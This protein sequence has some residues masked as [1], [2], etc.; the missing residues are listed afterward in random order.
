MHAV[1]YQVV[2]HA[3]VQAP[4]AQQEQY[5]RQFVLQPQEHTHADVLQEKDDREQHPEQRGQQAAAEVEQE[6][7]EAVH[8]AGAQ[9]QVEVVV[10]GAHQLGRVRR[11]AGR[12]HAG[13][14][15]AMEAAH[16]PWDGD[17]RHGWATGA[18]HGPQGRQERFTAGAA[19]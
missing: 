1:D 9:V 6:A 4:V 8:A 18:Q 16:P 12:V 13:G 3:K 15:G 5:H 11:P 17:H 10:L 14:V 7:E 2:E 19:S